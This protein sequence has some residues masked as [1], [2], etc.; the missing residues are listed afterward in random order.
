MPSRFFH[1]ALAVMC[2]A[3]ALTT[4]AVAQT[5]D[6]KVYYT[7]SNKVE[8]PGATLEPGRYL[9]HLVDPDSARQVLQVQS[10]DGKQV[11]AMF[12][13]VP[14]QRPDVTA[15]A[16]VRFFETAAGVPAAIRTVWYGGEKTGRE[17]IYPRSQATRIAATTNQPVLTTQGSTMTANETASGELTRVTPAGQD[18]QVAA[19][20]PSGA[21]EGGSQRGNADEKIPA[22]SEPVRQATAPQQPVDVMARNQAPRDAAVPTTRDRL[23]DTASPVPFAFLVGLGLVLSAAAL[24][25][26]RTSRA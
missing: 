16:E 15:D 21:P 9:F 10:G 3:T 5:V 17:L 8:I 1:S 19:N 13:T 11:F 26:W 4:S 22:A 20:V 12:F 18:T 24:R 7:F 25:F 2:A 6:K 23:P 14:A